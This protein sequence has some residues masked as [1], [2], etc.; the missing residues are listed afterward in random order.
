M[1]WGE[2]KDAG[3]KIRPPEWDQRLDYKRAKW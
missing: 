3:L 1:I 2:E